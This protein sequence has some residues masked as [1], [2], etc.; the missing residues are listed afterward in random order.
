MALLALMGLG[1]GAIAVGSRDDDGDREEATDASLP[2]DGEDDDATPI[3]ITP[4]APWDGRDSLL[5]PVDVTPAAELVDGQVVSVRGAG[6]PSNVSFGVV[7]C[8]TQAIELGVN[9]CDLGSSQLDQT[10]PDG[11]FEIS[12]T[13]RR[14]LTIGGSTVDCQTGNVDPA[15]WVVARAAGEPPLSVTDPTRFSCIVAAGVLNNYDQSGGFPVAFEGAL[16]GADA[17]PAQG[18]PI[19]APE[20]PDYTQVPPTTIYDIGDSVPRSALDVPIPLGCP[21]PPDEWWEEVYRTYPDLLPL[22]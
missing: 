5:L 12:F 2:D 1:V 21:P 3:E 16:I 15:D 18:P 7:M 10:R 13:V 9:A 14:H 8:T 19:T 22:N 6:F 20:C 17:P 4:Q 11:T